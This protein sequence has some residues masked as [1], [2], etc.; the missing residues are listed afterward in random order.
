[1]A[2]TTDTSRANRHDDADLTP[3]QR[4]LLPL[5]EAGESLESIA[6]LLQVSRRA[7]LTE[8]IVVYRKL[9]VSSTRAASEPPHL[10]LVAPPHDLRCA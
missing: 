6:A 10:R 9:Q 5:L 3:F 7:V 8:A 1:V 4:R 2:R